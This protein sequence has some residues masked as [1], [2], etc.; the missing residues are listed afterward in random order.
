[1]QK[2]DKTQST[3]INL[4]KKSPMKSLKKGNLP[5]VRSHKEHRFVRYHNVPPQILVE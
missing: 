4:R 2:F 5:N 3:N 1:M